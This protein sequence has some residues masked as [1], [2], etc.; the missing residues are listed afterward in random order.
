MNEQNIIL[1]D[2]IFSAN[3]YN[4]MSIRVLGNLKFR[5]SVINI[6]HFFCLAPFSHVSAAT[7]YIKILI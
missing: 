4:L 3:T 2:D 5:K 6:P 7:A 1:H